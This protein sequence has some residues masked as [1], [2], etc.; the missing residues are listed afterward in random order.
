MNQL[1]TTLPHTRQ[2]QHETRL[3]SDQAIRRQPAFL[4]LSIKTIVVHTVTY[5]LVGLLAMTVF[6]YAALFAES[7]MSQWLR[8]T[9]DPIVALGP[10]LQPLRGLLFAI[11]FYPLREVIFGRKHG[12]L[13]LWLVLVMIGIFSTFGPTPGSVEGLI[14][15]TVAPGRQLAG[16]VEV[17]L[18]ALLLSTVLCFWVEHAERRWL[19]WVLGILGVLAVALSITGFMMAGAA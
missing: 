1:R 3:T 19:A 6:D 12:W 11:A 10:A 2:A 8:Q 15:M 9:D 5:F 17:L 4:E 14:Y 18:Q 7:D 13:A 16:L